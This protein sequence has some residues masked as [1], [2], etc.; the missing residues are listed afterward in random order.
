MKYK[1]TYFPI[2]SGANSYPARMQ[3][4]LS[5]IAEINKLD[6]KKLAM[7]IL[8]FNLSKNDM[9]I[10][11]WVE[12]DLI[13]KN[14]FFSIKGVFKVLLKFIIF[15]IK[16]EQVVF[17]RHNI[18]PHKTNKTI[19]SKAEW[20][21]DVLER[22]CTSVIVHSPVHVKNGNIY[23][24]HPLY[25]YPLCNNNSNSIDNN[26]FIIFGRIV[27]Y[28]KYEQVIEFFPEEQKLLIAGDCEDSNYLKKIQDLVSNND[29]ITVSPFFLSDEQAK[30]LISSTAGMIISHA[31]DDM[32]VSGS[33]FYGLTLGIKM[34]AV[35]TPFLTW[36]EGI[37]GEE[38]IQTF[39]DVKTLCEYI[40]TK[41][42]RKK[43]SAEKISEINDLFSD[44][45][46]RETFYSILRRT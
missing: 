20:V 33:F 36:V 41:P 37:L 31:D 18:Y 1:I 29:N 2:N 8:K 9:I 28:K 15:K 21:V 13:G 10:L 3:N 22:L 14:G 39:P 16:F 11:N 44:E 19:G 6:L 4:I 27:E 12:S 35:A 42:L 34:F 17:V 7:E 5:S 26:L 40:A 25:E 23:I 45:K 46:I 43:I 38:V 32:I 24:P 30:E